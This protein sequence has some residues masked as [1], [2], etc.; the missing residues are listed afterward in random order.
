MAIPAKRL[1]F[2]F[3]KRLF[4]VSMC[5]LWGI[6]ST[7]VIHHA[8]QPSFKLEDLK[9]KPV[10][11]KISGVSKEKVN[12]TQSTAS[13]LKT[14]VKPLA[15]VKP[16]EPKPVATKK[17]NAIL[18]LKSKTIET[19]KP[20]ET[21]TN[22]QPF[23]EVI[24]TEDIEKLATPPEEF[25]NETIASLPA[26]PN[27]EAP[28]APPVGE[29]TEYTE[30]PGGSVLV[31]EVVLDDAGNVLQSKVAV[32]TFKPLTD[33]AIAWAIKAQRWQ[34]IDPPLKPGEIRKIVLRFPYA[35]EEAK[36]YPELP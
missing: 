27:S 8:L 11:V 23:K 20:I 30:I 12:T 33:V 6:V 13:P 9:A 24:N 34:N 26:I 3:N 21:G 14:P 2:Q 31:L 32:P 4:S 36:N 17:P 35:D 28:P 29:T 19:A 16:T 10:A 7:L 1:T 18:P 22:D 25:V 5:Y 15:E